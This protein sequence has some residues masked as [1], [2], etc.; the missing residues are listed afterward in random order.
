MY[1]VGKNDKSGNDDFFGLNY[2]HISADH[3]FCKWAKD[4]RPGAIPEVILPSVWYSIILH[5]SGRATE[6]DCL[7]LILTYAPPYHYRQCIIGYL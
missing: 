2:F 4:I 3:P 6:D 7:V 5:Y 1:V